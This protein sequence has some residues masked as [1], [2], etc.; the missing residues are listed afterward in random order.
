ML[1]VV[2]AVVSSNVWSISSEYHMI[3]T[4]SPVSQVGGDTSLILTTSWTSSIFDVV[5]DDDVS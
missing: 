5:S 3:Q 1:T 2:T 4:W